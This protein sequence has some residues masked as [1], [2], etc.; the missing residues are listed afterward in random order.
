MVALTAFAL[1]CPVP[2]VA[3]GTTFSALWFR[4]VY[5]RTW[6]IWCYAT[7]QCLALVAAL[8]WWQSLPGHDTPAPAG[9]VLGALPLVFLLAVVA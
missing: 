8:A 5:G 3:F 7:G 2:A 1:G 4:A 9:P 6:E